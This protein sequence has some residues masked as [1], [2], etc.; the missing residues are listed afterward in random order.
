MVRG[1]PAEHP[2]TS[3][4]ESS[5][6]GDAGVRL[7]ECRELLRGFFQEKRNLQ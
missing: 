2:S 3:G 7:D 1:E 4:L 5:M 6:P